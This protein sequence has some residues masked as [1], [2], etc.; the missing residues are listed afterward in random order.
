VDGDPAAVAFGQGPAETVSRAAFM[1]TPLF[2]GT[3]SPLAMLG[4][5]PAVWATEAQDT[6]V[7]VSGG[8]TSFD[9]G[10]SSALGVLGDLGVFGLLAYAGL[11]LGLFVRL[12]R[13]TSAEGIAAASGLALFIILGLV[14]DWWEQ[15]PLG[16]TIAVLA[17]LSLSES[18]GAREDA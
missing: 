6:A 1:T 2:L 5:K 14:F 17:G 7:E 4:L 8:G 16:V 11:L 10:T 3:D 13:E 9:S 15:P 18:Q 12:R